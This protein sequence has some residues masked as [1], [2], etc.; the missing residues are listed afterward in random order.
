MK[1]INCGE[2]VFDLVHCSNCGISQEEYIFENINEISLTQILSYIFQSS[3]FDS[4]ISNLKSAFNDFLVN[5]KTE[6]N[7]LQLIITQELILKLKNLNE[8]DVI[9]ILNI[10]TQR[11]NREYMIDKTLI[12]SLI[13]SMIASMNPNLTLKD[14]NIITTLENDI[15]FK[16]ESLISELELY[17]NSEFKKLTTK[18][19]TNTMK[20]ELSNKGI[21]TIDGIE[22]F[23]SLVEI[24]ISYNPIEDVTMLF[25]IPSLKKINVKNTYLDEL[26]ILYLRSYS[27][28]IDI[29]FDRELLKLTDSEEKF[30]VLTQESN[31]PKN[32]YLIGKHYYDG[33]IVKENRSTALKWFSKASESNQPDALYMIAKY[34]E[35]GIGLIVNKPKA[36][37]LYK[38]AASLGNKQA[39]RKINKLEREIFRESHKTQNA[40]HH[41]LNPGIVIKHNTKK[42]TLSF[43]FNFFFRYVNIATV[44]WKSFKEEITIANYISFAIVFLI[45]FTTILSDPYEQKGLMFI[46]IAYPISF[47]I[48][49]SMIVYSISLPIRFIKIILSVINKVYN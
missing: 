7:I 5:Y 40:K 17:F 15:F 13:K 43:I 36:L 25:N 44:G 4:K 16:D 35:S 41:D 46:I 31:N 14:D 45:C 21:E 28:K 20:L 48:F 11:I 26:S 10:E 12:S 24:D 29:T 38:K 1:C 9:R 22:Q 33:N 6:N 42:K 49:Y 27:S 19:I 3:S 32:Q 2:N 47:T 30:F 34:F 8:D 23:K 18:R 37:E 39:K